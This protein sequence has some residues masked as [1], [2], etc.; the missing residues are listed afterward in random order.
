MQKTNLVLVFG[1]SVG[2][3]EDIIS[4]GNFRLRLARSLMYL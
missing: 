1:Y 3:M 4:D 2:T